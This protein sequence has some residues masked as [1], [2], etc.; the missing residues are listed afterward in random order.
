MVLQHTT[1]QGFNYQIALHLL[2]QYMLKY[3]YMTISIAP[4]YLYKSI[5]I[6]KYIYL[7]MPYHKFPFVYNQAGSKS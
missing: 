1:E 3:L 6:Q 5:I 4:L 2:F 7:S